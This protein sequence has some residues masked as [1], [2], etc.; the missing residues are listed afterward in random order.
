MVEI[1]FDEEG[2]LVRPR[3]LRL[4]LPSH[5]IMEE[6]P[7]VPQESEEERTERQRK[8]WEEMDARLED[9]PVKPWPMGDPIVDKYLRI[10][11][12]G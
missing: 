9:I 3:R 11:G 5:F 2:R 8:F 1:V 6:E 12:Q 7:G 10:T 4:R